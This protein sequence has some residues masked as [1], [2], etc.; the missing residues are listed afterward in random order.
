MAVR[1]ATKAK[2]AKARPGRKTARKATRR[3]AAAPAT[4]AGSGAAR[5][6]ARL[7]EENHRLRARIAELEAQATGQPE[8]TPVGEPEEPTHPM[9]L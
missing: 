1:K 9:D 6:V 3:K 8:S 2:K 5:E 4:S 7:R